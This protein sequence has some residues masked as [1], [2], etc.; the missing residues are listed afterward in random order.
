MDRA[1]VLVRLNFI[2]P[3]KARS[4]INCISQ[5]YLCQVWSTARPFSSPAASPSALRAIARFS[6]SASARL[7]WRRSECRPVAGTCRTMASGESPPSKERRN[8]LA[9]EKSPYLLQHASNPVDWWVLVISLRNKNLDQIF[10]IQSEEITEVIEEKVD[11]VQHF[12]M[13]FTK[14]GNPT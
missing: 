8:R 14:C 1:A 12:S 11:C 9:N 10:I 4:E 7:R 5:R 2:R 3:F 13:Y 6:S